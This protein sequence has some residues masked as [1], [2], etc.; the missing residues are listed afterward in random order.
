MQIAQIR[1]PILKGIQ[2]ATKRKWKHL[3]ISSQLSFLTVL[4]P[5]PSMFWPPLSSTWLLGHLSTTTLTFFLPHPMAWRG[6]AALDEAFFSSIDY[7]V[8]HLFVPIEDPWVLPTHIF[9]SLAS[10]KYVVFGSAG[11][12]PISLFP[13]QRIL[14]RTIYVRRVNFLKAERFSCSWTLT[15]LL[16]TPVRW[17]THN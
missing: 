6:S 3:F 7:R 1:A 14:R 15:S 10:F 5:F 8:S 11:H 2:T 17:K 16:F 12:F 9:S 4:L 13:S